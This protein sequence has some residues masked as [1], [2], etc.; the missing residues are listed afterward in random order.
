MWL[1]DG[2]LFCIFNKGIE[3]DLETA[4]VCVKGRLDYSKGK[5]FPCVIDLTGLRSI[6]REARAFMGNEGAQGITAGAMITGNP[7]SRFIGN[8]FL[9]LNKPKVPAR[10]F[11]DMASATEWIK[12]QIK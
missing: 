10:L 6:T 3:I 7:L 2:I 8:A 9:T 12:K 1:E 11:G 5:S 4:R